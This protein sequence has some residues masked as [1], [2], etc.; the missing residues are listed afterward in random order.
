MGFWQS[1]STI[2]NNPSDLIADEETF[3]AVSTKPRD[4]YYKTISQGNTLTKK[5]H[6]CLAVKR[7]QI[8][9]S[10]KTCLKQISKTLRRKIA[11]LK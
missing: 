2:D 5:R 3:T 8:G 6:V 4:V 11:F 7:V 9:V 1:L 10:R